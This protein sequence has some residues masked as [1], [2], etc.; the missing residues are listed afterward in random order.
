M[1]A[2]IYLN[3]LQYQPPKKKD[4]FDEGL[5]IGQANEQIGSLVGKCKSLVGHPYEPNTVISLFHL[6]TGDYTEQVLRIYKHVCFEKNAELRKAGE[7][8]HVEV[9]E[10]DGNLYFVAGLYGKPEIGNE[11]KGSFVL[12]LHNASEEEYLNSARGLDIEDKEHFLAVVKDAY[13]L[14]REGKIDLSHVLIDRT[15]HGYQIEQAEGKVGQQTYGLSSSGRASAV[16]EGGH[17]FSTAITAEQFEMLRGLVEQAAGKA[18]EKLLKDPEELAN[19]VWK[20][21]NNTGY[22]VGWVEE[23]VSLTGF[24]NGQVIT[25]GK[26][27]QTLRNAIKEKLE[28]KAITETGKGYVEFVGTDNHDYKAIQNPKDNSIQVYRKF[29]LADSNS[30]ENFLSPSEVID[31]RAGDCDEITFLA[32]KFIQMAGYQGNLIANHKNNR[33]F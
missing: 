22:N 2:Q 3:P 6:N 23:N 5:V 10:M 18:L 32:A 4:I 27:G 24:S 1:P 31:R 16:S 13:H 7:N 30:G 21:L 17:E 15:E 8:I 26:K 19:N 29:I 9:Q 12:E 14:A 33:T 28:V 20:V 11:L 25:L